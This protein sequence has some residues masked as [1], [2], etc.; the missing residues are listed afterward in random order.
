MLVEHMH[1]LVLL[2]PTLDLLHLAHTCRAVANVACDKMYYHIYLFH[3]CL[4]C[5]TLA[6]IDA[7]HC[8]WCRDAM[9]WLDGGLP[10]PEKCRIITTT[11][12]YSYT[13][14][15]VLT[16]RADPG[17]HTDW[18]W[19]YAFGVT[20]NPGAHAGHTLAASHQDDLG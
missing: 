14:H 6:I 4:R 17:D 20:L 19:S 7:D 1:L 2:L 12:E 3:I 10:G 16:P 9:T 5:N 18:V 8:N 15:R 13:R 11:F